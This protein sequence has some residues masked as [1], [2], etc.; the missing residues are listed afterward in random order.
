MEFSRY[1]KRSLIV[2]TIAAGS[3]STAILA[4]TPASEEANS[5]VLS[6]VNVVGNPSAVYS[7]PGSAHYVD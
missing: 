6:Q 1:L 5:A 3:F 7:I 4:E 2:F